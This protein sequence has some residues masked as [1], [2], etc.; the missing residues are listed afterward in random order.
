MKTIKHIMYLLAAGCLVFCMSCSN[1]D[2]DTSSQQK[3]IA[4]AQAESALADGV[5]GF[6][7]TLK[8]GETTL[9]LQLVGEETAGATLETGTYD[10]TRKRILNTL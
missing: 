4:F 5:G 6:T 10:V 1:D 8:S 2:T 7:V 9:Y 3:N